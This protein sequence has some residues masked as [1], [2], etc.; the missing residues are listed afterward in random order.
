MSLSIRPGE[1]IAVCGPSG[2]GKTSLILSLLRMI[3]I[4]EGN[5]TVDGVDISTLPS[6]VVRRRINVVPQEAF[7]MPGTLRF[8]IDPGIEQKFVSDEHIIA[9]VQEVGLWSKVCSSGD[10]G[11]ELDMPLVAS[12]WSLGER[13]LLALARALITKI[14]LLLL[15]K[16]TSR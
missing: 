14:P 8:N 6:D 12:N 7:F 5:I 2:S 9:A 11:K 13:Q 3:E 4:R 15:D 10:E 16:A 1:K